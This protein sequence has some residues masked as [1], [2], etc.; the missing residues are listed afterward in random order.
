MT[1]AD[2]EIHEAKFGTTWEELEWYLYEVPRGAIYTFKQIEEKWVAFITDPL[3]PCLRVQ[4]E[5]E[6]IA[7]ALS[8]AVTAMLTVLHEQTMATKH[9]PG[10]WK[11]DNTQKYYPRNCIRHNGMVVCHMVA[12]RESHGKLRKGEYSDDANA[13]L[14]AAAPDYHSAAQRVWNSAGPPD[15]EH[16]V[17]SRE[18]YDAL[19]AAHA[20]AEEG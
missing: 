19:A 1:L 2:D 3:S 17:I 15:D 10:P 14:I 20:K 18:A 7:D 12:L 8:S 4:G 16:V 6:N 13:R 11:I 9:T 5:G